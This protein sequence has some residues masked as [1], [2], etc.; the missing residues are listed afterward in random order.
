MTTSRLAR[1]SGMVERAL[2]SAGRGEGRF[3][4]RGMGV[5]L[6]VYALFALTF[7]SFRV[8]NDGLVYYTFLRRFLGEDV[9]PGGHAYQ[10]GVAFFNAPFYLAARAV[11]AAV[12]PATVLGA[13]LREAAIGVASNVA[14]LLTL[15]LGWRMLRRLD[16]PAGPAVLL[17]T[18]FGSPLFYYTA[19][20]PSY[21]HAV[22]ALALTA[23]AWLLLLALESPSPRVLVGLGAC[24][25]FLVSLRYANVAL[26][27]G[28]LLPFALRREWRAAGRVALA[29]VAA[30]GV[31]FALPPA[32]DIP[33]ERG[34][35]GPG[36]PRLLAAGIGIPDPCP[37]EP[38]YRIDWSQCLRNKLGVRF[39]LPAPAR[40]LVSTR[41]GLFLWTPLTAF[42]VVGFLLL[43]RA[44][45]ER[46]RFLL[47][48]GVAAASLVAIHALWGDF[49]T[50]G[51]SF[52]QR[53]LASLFPVYLLG[54]AELVRRWRS[55]AAG[56]LALC[57]AFSLY[58]GFNHFFGY[59]GI[60]ER[61]G[62]VEVLSTDGDRGVGETLRLI[63][64]RAGERWGFR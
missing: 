37:D 3:L 64:Q 20:Q 32:R 19:F 1:I 24:L 18:V 46:R 48:L 30:G 53:F 59:E 10:F 33:F 12:G 50:N 58:L 27:P 11:D 35:A 44:R 62:I 36:A 38:K 13:P 23:A 6:A 25:A 49:W 57:A 45:A 41:R 51:F 29:L 52:S 63:G 4:S 26:V 43:A 31:L 7:A 16:L 60:S 2:G 17:L 54:V 28:M 34:T 39:D 56:V 8:A 42:A 15:W 5:S 21:K 22:D 9:A 14:L 40:M 55:A 61:D 47:G